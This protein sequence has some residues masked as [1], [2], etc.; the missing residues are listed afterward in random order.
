MEKGFVSRFNGSFFCKSIVFLIC[1]VFLVQSCIWMMPSAYST[2]VFYHEKSQGIISNLADAFH[3]A[4][5]LFLPSKAYAA[6]SGTEYITFWSG[7]LRIIA[8]NDNTKITLIDIDTG[9]PLSMSDSRINRSLT[10]FLTNPFVLNEA[11]DSFEGVGGLGGPNAEIRVR[12][13][14]SSAEGGP[15]PKPVTIWTG[16]LSS[17]TRH[18]SNP[19]SDG[20]PWMSYIPASVILMESN[21]Q[22]EFGREV[23]RSFLGFTTK[24]M[25]I[26]ALKDDNTPTSIAIEDLITNTD[27]DSDDSTVLTTGSPRKVFENSEI[28]IYFI[29]TFED[30]T[31]RITSNVDISVLVGY[32]SQRGP[33]WTVT[34]PSYAKGDKGI[35]RGTLFY[36]FA[37]RYLTVFPLETDTTVAIT[38]LSDTDD[39]KTITLTTGEDFYQIYTP[40]LAT[41]SSGNIIPRNSSPTVTIL[42]NN[43]NAF[44]DDFV[45]IQSDK[46]ILVYVGPVGS[47]TIEF[48]DVAF[49]V[50]TGPDSRI[51]YTFAQ[52]YG[53]SNDLQVFAFDPDTRVTI[54]SLSYTNG[55]RGNGQHDFT[56]GPGIGGTNGWLEGTPGGDVWWG[57]GIW[58]AEML[59]IES[60][61]PITVLNGDYDAPCF[62]AFIPFTPSGLLEPVADAGEDQNINFRNQVCFDGTGSYDQD[63]ID[64]GCTIK[65][66]W[67]F[68]I[69]YDSDGDNIPDNDPDSNSPTF[70]HEYSSPGTY[71][72]RLEFWDDDCQWDDDF[73]IITVSFVPHPPTANAN[74]PYI[75]AM[76]ENITL[77]GSGSYD[78]DEPDGDSITAYD[79][80]IDMDFPY[81]FDEATGVNP[82]IP[83]FDTKGVYSIGLR[84]TDDTAN[85][86]SFTGSPNLT[87]EDFT[88]I[89]IYDPCIIDL[90]VRPKGTKAQLVWTHIG[91]DEYKIYRSEKGANTGMELIG[92]TDS[93]YSTF[94]DYNVELYKDYWYRVIVIEDN[95]DICGSYAVHIISQGRIRNNPP[96]ITSTPPLTAHEGQ[97]YGYDVEATDPDGDSITY[98]LDQAPDGMT[99]DNATGFI[100]WTPTASQIGPHYITVRATDSLGASAT[101]FY[102]LTVN[103]RPND[104]PVANPGG[105]YGTLLGE[106]ITFDGSESYDPDGDL[107]LSYQ[108]NFGDGIISDLPNPTHTYTSSG[109]YTVTLFVTDSRGASGQAQTTAIVNARPVAQFTSQ[110]LRR[111]GEDFDFDA[112]SSYDTDG[113]IVEYEWDFGDGNTAQGEILTYSYQNPGNYTVSLKVTDDLGATDTA[114]KDISVV[115]N[116]PPEIISIPITTATEDVLYTYDVDATDPDGDTLT[117]SLTTAPSGMAIDAASGLI[118]WVPAREQAG[119]QIVDVLAEDGHGNSDSQQYTIQVIQTSTI[120]PNIIGMTQ[121]NAETTIISAILEVGT[122]GLAYSDTVPE[123]LVVSQEPV[124]GTVVSLN[125]PVDF[126][127]SLGVADIDL[128][129][130]SMDTSNVIVDSQNLG[131]TGT[132]DVVIKNNGTSNVIDS[133][134][135][136]LFEDINTNNEFDAGTD[137][138]LGTLILPDGPLGSDMLTIIVDVSGSMLFKGNLIHAFVDSENEIAETDEENNITNSM[139]DCELIPPVGSF[140]PVLEWAWTSSSVLPDWLNVMM[141]PAVIDLN[142]DNIPDIVFGSTSS[143]GGAYVEIG[144]LRALSGNNGAELFTVTDSSLYVNTA[145]S[146]A[147]GD[148]DLDGKPEIV[149]CDSTGARLF[150]FENDGTF[151]WRSPYLE[152]I[153]WGAPSLCD[154]DMDGVTELIIGRQ[155]LN[156][157]GSIRWTG[158]GGRGSLGAIGPLSFAA[159]LNLDGSPEIVAGN[160][161]YFSSGIIFWQQTSLPDGLNAVADFDDDPFPEIVLVSGGRVWL[162]EHNGAVKWGPVSIPGGGNG[163]PPTVADFDNDGEVEIG[164]AGASR[165]TVFD[166][167]GGI[168][169]ASVTQDASS[170]VTGSSVF[171]FDGDGSS[172]VVYRDELYLR[173]YRGIDGTILFQVPM[174]SCT[175]YEYVLVADVD[176]DNNA[177]ILAVANNNCG[178]GPQRGIYVFGDLNDTWINTR[179]IWNQHAYHIT[180]I[181]DDGSIPQYEANNWEIYNNFRQNQMIQPFGCID[182]IASYIRVNLSNCPDVEIIA[183]I[184]NG[185]ALHTAPGLKVA[186]Y[187][188]D[189][190]SGGTLLGTK[191]VDIQLNPGEYTDISYINTSSLYKT[192]TLYV[193]ADDDGTGFG[194]VLEIDEE[195]NKASATFDLCNTIPTITSS[196][197]TSANEDFPYNYDVEAND[198]DGDILTYSLTEA[199]SGMSI[200]SVTG[201]IQWTPLQDHVGD[202]NVTVQVQ[203]G[204]GGIDTQSFT[205]TV[206]NTND[207]PQITSTPTLTAKENIV[208]SYDVEAFDI[209]ED[210]LTFTLEIAPPGMTI[211]S[212]SGL[213]EWTPGSSDIG[214]HTIKVKVTDPSAASDT[215]EY[216]LTVEEITDFTPPRISE[217]QIAPLILNPGETATIAID[218]IDNEAIGSY[219]LQVDGIDI[220]LIGNSATYTAATIG[221]HE[222][223][224]TVCDTSGNCDTLIA[225]F[226]VRDPS[227]TTPPEVSISTPAT[228]SELTA[229]TDLRGTAS[230]ENLVSYTLEYSEKDKNNFVKFYKGNTEVLEDVLGTLNPSLLVNGLY[231]IRLSAVD[232]NGLTNSVMVTY[233]IT[234]DLKVGNFTVTFKDLEIPVAGIPITIYRTYDSRIRHYKGDFGYGWN[235]D[236]RTTK[237]EENREL[238]KGWYQQASGG[239]IKTYYLR[240]DGE[241]YVSITLPDGQTLEFDCKFTPESQTLY[242][243]QWLNSAVYSPRPGTNGSLTALDDSPM[244][245]DGSQVLNWDFEIY[246]P[247]RYQLTTIDGTV[248][249]I[250]QTE[251]LK[252]VTDNNSNSLDITYNGIIHSTGKS[253]NFTRDAQGRITEIADPMGN[254]LLYEYD[255]RSDL[256]AFTDQEGNTS[257][258]TYNSN[259]GLVD[260]F[261]PTGNRPMR[262][263]YDY[264]GSLIAHI[265]AEGN[266]I[267]YNHDPDNRQEIVSDR[268]GNITVFEYDDE[269]N[270][271]KK[272]DALGNITTYTYDARGNTLSET[273]PLGNT[274]TYTYDAK[275]NMLTKTDPL[276]NTTSYTYNAKGRPLTITDP[277][278]NITTNTYDAKGNLLSITDPI[279]NVLTNTYDAGGNL[280]SGT[281]PLGNVTGYSYDASG[282]MTS[283]TDPLGNITTFTYDNNGNE[284]TKTFT[285]TTSSG[286]ETISVQSEY[287]SMNRLIKN[288]DP[289]GNSTIT[290]YNAVG[291]RSATI[292][293]NG[294]RADYEYDGRGNIE[295]ITYPD[296][297]AETSTYDAEGRKISSTDRAGRTTQYIYDAL[298]RIIKT[299]YPDGSS[300]TG[301]YDAAGRT[302]T[303]TDT[304]GNTTS[305]TYDAAGHRTSIID[306]YGNV[307][308]YTYDANGNQITMTDANGNTYVYEYD[309]NNR[310][311]KTIFP[312]GTFTTTTYN[313]IGWKTS[314]TDQA[315]NTTNFDYDAK[316]QLI[317]VTDALGNITTYEYDELGNKISQTDANGNS[318]MWEY[319]KLGRVTKKIMPLGMVEI[320]EY[321]AVGNI[322]SKTDFNGNTTTYTY[323]DNNRILQK[324]YPDGSSVSYIYNSSGQKIS[325][326]DSRGLTTYEYDLLNRLIK[327]TDPDGTTISYTYDA[328][329]NR[330]SVTTPSDTTMYSYDSL[331]R[332]KTVTD[333]DLGVT[334]YSY[335]KLGNRINVQYP[336]GTKA[337]YTYDILNRLIRLENKRSDDSI[338][339]SY[340]YTLGP[341]GNRIIVQEH[342]GRTVEYTYDALYRLTKEKITD[343]VHG[344]RLISY[345]YDP[346]GNRLTKSDSVDGTINYTYDNNDR[347]LSENG[348]TYTYDNNGNTIT[349][350]E[351]SNITTYSYDYENRPVE[352][353][354]PTSLISY[355]YDSDGIKVSSTVNGAV[356]SYLVDKNRAYAQVL[357]ETDAGSSLIAGYVHG[358]DLISMKRGSIQ[359]FYHYDGNG[360][361]RELTDFSETITDTYIYDAFGV[362][363]NRTGVTDNNYL[364][365]GEQY[366]VNIGFYYLRAR[367]YNQATGR[368]LTSDPMEPFPGS[369][370]DP[371]S[372]HLYVYTKNNPVNYIDPSGNFGICGVMISIAVISII[373]LI[374][375]TWPG[376]FIGR[377]YKAI[378][379]L[380]PDGII[381]GAAGSVHLLRRIPKFSGRL[382]FGYG[383][384]AGIEWVL[385][386][387]SSEEGFFFYGG[388]GASISA[389]WNVVR[390]VAFV[391]RLHNLLGHYAGPSNAFGI[392]ERIQVGFFFGTGSPSGN[393]WGLVYSRQI[394]GSSGFGISGVRNWARPLSVRSYSTMWPMV[395]YA[396]ALGAIIGGYLGRNA[397][398]TV[399]GATMGYI[400]PFTKWL[401]GPELR[402]RQA[403]RK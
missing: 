368:F 162:L 193:V 101:Q 247:N 402:S 173:V 151:K 223:Q 269:G 382:P 82:N 182:L 338:L 98:Y 367:Y 290:E 67:D 246:N 398:S 213:I 128:E 32:S 196:P 6:V 166:T 377:A 344:D 12:I 125:S 221:V 180:N 94:L 297:T 354:T 321:D 203:D 387:G 1:Y 118:T 284:L 237:V 362:I 304:R 299:I 228:D 337:L 319:D 119:D 65:Y 147:A 144:V 7:D 28:E 170:N 391:Y 314:E 153:Y 357:E 251:G 154:I 49:S 219:E 349:K 305:Y 236:I 288:T 306:P 388:F 301:T 14:S 258:Y 160:T 66:K 361:T 78:I 195:N 96:R 157:D 289:Y 163:G 323:D 375:I 121:T 245:F 216:S 210:P 189:P 313:E 155:V 184:G 277:M 396:T 226:G 257:Q 175:W 88:E 385:N 174:S 2:R 229:P 397:A 129:P 358:D 371:P 218:A 52:N 10:I 353:N 315:G 256:V 240:P 56:I 85:A 103:P 201:L 109:Q 253:V 334:T 158:T 298:G 73:V 138:I 369:I 159:D 116:F 265:D 71:T 38:D 345:S 383:G 102:I 35:E 122:I 47:N 322:L 145:S 232:V 133:Y 187:D 380:L 18:P 283:Q 242:P 348:T 325:E 99:I 393:Y 374:A 132:V 335:D 176:N 3:D 254:S 308:N 350:T 342:T 341:V 9:A 107:P 214:D 215:Q 81:D 124:A 197:I 281:D 359:Y 318:T 37:E 40:T 63:T 77:D 339:S 273:D 206:Q 26:F 181:N 235:I 75:S 259:H 205:I 320:T 80:E 329:G 379:K 89:R 384:Q 222:I 292:D 266:R 127:L 114:T 19:P 45:K 137:N 255:V 90:Y 401:E 340:N 140:D 148:I 74:G 34:P 389:S 202:N 16:S 58:N 394:I 178:K 303:Q 188:G 134:V 152:A 167:N 296:G 84:V 115:L 136:T 20:N 135:I 238:G 317:S 231:D 372:L 64:S 168:L 142:D 169:W 5:E 302:T 15:E 24:E 262:N 360:N 48:A 8:H 92:V 249:I 123:G 191:T 400:W 41:T 248:Y 104:S 356:T 333:P 22:G 120:V 29:N 252:R 373:N 244:Y 233:R 190:D 351:G 209:D 276:G 291:K 42:N 91:A 150:V 279:G 295:K 278:G 44:D 183:R 224:A 250:D 365:T 54:T 172:E 264:D 274:T 112:S 363:L 370:Y 307:T 69:T 293:Q 331:N 204:R 364:Y 110:D 61:K 106:A 62:G 326:L 286:T 217:I 287:D 192:H 30:D 68:D 179:K 86:F 212:A 378:G 113:D 225:L 327:R 268:L 60:T 376:S 186:F 33:D 57:S 156:N 27:P 366:D 39:S 53:N 355:I 271:T 309:K 347:L 55:F 352:V 4:I 294:N 149:A 177:E 111:V 161:A 23:G 146:V 139:A 343:P 243:I 198:P 36:T 211:D 282:N 272:T 87:G 330:A 50:P 105:P 208:Y 324:I 275:D 72:A 316:G 207:P 97:P 199:P 220:P 126:V 143:R 185:G 285:R 332:L 300:T 165:Y 131:I 395:G 25:Y 227:D 51:I 13:I 130:T 386:V 399:V 117:Y 31:V 392:G 230:D 260:I 328:A 234:G 43:G 270:V 93:T 108:W 311:I 95:E 70:C 83:V 310:L 346:V 79:W 76:G 239:L 381:L 171:D 11:G 312:D 141:T 21:D 17:S 390:Y 403:W 59:R 241:H 194:R 200:D 267:E 100:S 280:S 164:V 336:N 263:E 261:D 46:P